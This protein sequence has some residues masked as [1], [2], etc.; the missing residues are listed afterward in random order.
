MSDL[1]KKIY[2]IYAGDHANPGERVDEYL[3]LFAPYEKLVEAVTAQ[4]KKNPF[5]LSQNTHAALKP[6]EPKRPRR[7]TVEPDSPPFT[8]DSFDTIE[9]TDEVRAA[10]EAAGIIEE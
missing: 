7:Y 9:L 3:A 10:L 4:N 1:R 8:M 5:A 6:F 2:N